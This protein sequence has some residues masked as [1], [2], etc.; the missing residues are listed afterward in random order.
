[1]EIII[2][3]YNYDIF[4]SLNLVNYS[5]KIVTMHDVCIELMYTQGATEVARS[6]T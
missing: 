5:Y 4:G 3:L 1:M 2:F 6:Q